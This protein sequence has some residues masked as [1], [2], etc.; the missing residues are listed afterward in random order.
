MLFPRWIC[1][2]NMLKTLKIKEKER[3][4]IFRDNISNRRHR[5]HLKGPIDSC[6]K[7]FLP[8]A[9]HNFPRLKWSLRF[10][11]HFYVENLFGVMGIDQSQSRSQQQNGWP[12]Q[13]HNLICNRPV[14]ARERESSYSFNG[15][16]L[17][18]WLEAFERFWCH[19]VAEAAGASTSLQTSSMYFPLSFSTTNQLSSTYAQASRVLSLRI[20]FC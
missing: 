2:E 12:F 3:T 15:I 6:D 4:T 7:R 11:T 9:S 13:C 10:K 19:F 5:R 20:F 18:L 17:F 1:T 16:K 8:G 14:G